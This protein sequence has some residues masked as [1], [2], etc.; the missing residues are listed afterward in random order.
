MNNTNALDDLIQQI[1]TRLIDYL[2]SMGV[3]VNENGR[4][5]SITP[6]Y[7]SSGKNCSI[8]PKSNGILWKSFSE[9]VGGDIFNACNLIEGKPLSGPEWISETVF[10]LA[11]KLSIPYDPAALITEEM[12]KDIAARKF[13]D[14][15]AELLVEHGDFT[16]AKDRG[17]SEDVCRL[18]GIASIKTEFVRN[19]LVNSGYSEQ[20]LEEY[21]IDERLFG[22]RFITITIRNASGSVVGFARRDVDWKSARINPDGS[23]IV[24]PGSKYMNS[25][26]SRVFQ[27]R[28][29][30]QGLNLAVNHK[31]KPLYV[32]EG[33]GSWIKMIETGPRNCCCT[34]GTAFTDEQLRLVKSLGFRQI[35]LCFDADRAGEEGT[36]RFLDENIKLLTDIEIYIVTVEPGEESGENDAEWFISKH[37]LAAFKA[38]PLVDMFEWRMQRAG[39]EDG[40]K[41]A[42]E[43]VPFIACDP[44]RVRWDRKIRTLSEVT[45]ISFDL[46]LL[47]VERIADGEKQKLA[48]MKKKLISNSYYNM[49]ESDE[50]QIEAQQLIIE[51]DQMSETR[52]DNAVSIAYV[53][54]RISNIIQ[55]NERTERKDQ[56]WA[57][58]FPRLNKAMDGGFPRADCYI[59]F[60]GLPNY[61]KSAIMINLIHDML[62]ENGDDLLIYFMT[63]DDAARQVVPRL[64]SRHS[65]ITAKKV[66]SPAGR[67][68]PE[69]QLKYDRAKAWLDDNIGRGK[70]V[71]TDQEDGNTLNFALAKIR[72]LKRE[73]KDK[74]ILFMLDNFHK[75]RSMKDGRR[76]QV[77]ELS[78]TLQTMKTAMEMTIVTTLEVNKASHGDFRA[79]AFVGRPRLKDLSESG[80]IE[81]DANAIFLIYNQ[82]QAKR[83]NCQDY[84]MKKNE[85]GEMVQMPFVEM[86]L[87]KN[88]V[89][90]EKPTIY[91]EF[92]PEINYMREVDEREAK[93]NRSN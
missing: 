40:E 59:G 3:D 65:G 67:L 36:K 37:G 31:D 60:G 47:D 85:K 86:E 30:L 62:I 10:Y 63:I 28:K 26:E 83:N 8:N 70:L 32:F 87:A 81:Y 54:D 61:G 27:K 46:I 16:L 92:D 50:P 24:Y 51:L 76:E 71:I 5:K 41:I 55:E 80:K 66:A 21:A 34:G 44:R 93:R 64:L 33:F 4:F 23:K 19:A 35:A 49:L 18:L 39:S 68:D 43:M 88:K 77:I 74:Q 15:V 58:G 48:D 78:D 6:G 14:M 2:N 79:G 17:W 45:N 9:G 90:G 13:L 75:L 11:D 29:I 1:R 84:W 20:L 82:L 56:V 38:L 69:E 12:A 22:E 7:E 89:T 57:T 91:L 42:E 73:F 72:W 53:R 52:N 25:P